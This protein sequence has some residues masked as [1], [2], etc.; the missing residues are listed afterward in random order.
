MSHKEQIMILFQKSCNK[1]KTI[2]TVKSLKTTQE[3]FAILEKMKMLLASDSYEYVG[4]NNPADT[5]KY[6]AQDGLW[7]RIKCKHCGAIFTLWYNTFDS[8][9]HFKKGK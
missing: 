7:Y 2:K 8:K 9:G 1:C 3:F 6:W 4:G 5:I